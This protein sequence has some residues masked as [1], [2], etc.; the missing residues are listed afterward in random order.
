MK[1]L[2]DVRKRR[3]LFALLTTPWVGAALAALAMA[4]LT[5]ASGHL[6][7]AIP[8]FIKTLIYA[9]PVAWACAVVFGL[10][11]LIAGRALKASQP[12]TCMLGGMLCAAPLAAW[13]LA[14]T[15]S[16]IAVFWA[17]VSLIAGT[18][19]GGTFWVFTLGPGR[20]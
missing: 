18:A 2:Q 6:A 5:A 14:Q 9:M 15:F 11:T 3:L 16:G 1:T 8:V 20:R 10:P 4:A 12:A 19:S 13:L 17:V 7:Q